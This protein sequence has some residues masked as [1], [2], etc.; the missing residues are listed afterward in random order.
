MAA[1]QPPHFASDVTGVAKPANHIPTNAPCAQC[2][3][4]AATTPCTRHSTHQGVA[5]CLTCHGP[6]VAAAFANIKITTT[7]GNHIPIGGLDCNGSGCHSTGN[8]NP[9]A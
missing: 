1:I 9:A 8:V 3:T 4:T 6:T 5:N 7:P 2:H